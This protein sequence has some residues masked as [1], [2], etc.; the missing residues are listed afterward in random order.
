VLLIADLE[1]ETTSLSITQGSTTARLGSA[2]MTSS[3]GKQPTVHRCGFPTVRE[4][5]P[6][7]A[8]P[9]NSLE[10]ST[11]TASSLRRRI[12]TSRTAAGSGST[13]RRNRRGSTSS[14]IASHDSG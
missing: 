13:P 1:G 2:P 7:P 12:S 10:P 4:P 11:F 14:S 8:A 9:A 5:D 3:S 6:R